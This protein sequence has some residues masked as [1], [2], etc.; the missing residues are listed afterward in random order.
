VEEEK[1]AECAATAQVVLKVLVCCMVL[2]NVL[3]KMKL[4]A[5][6][7]LYGAQLLDCFLHPDRCVWRLLLYIPDV[8]CTPYIRVV[9]PGM[10]RR[11]HACWRGPRSCGCTLPFP[12]RRTRERSQQPPKP[13]QAKIG[14][15]Q[16]NQFCLGKP[17]C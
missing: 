10:G 17:R 1:V 2:K 11:P 13:R 3:R 5:T 12:P 7:R 16:P 9:P 4:V 15:G 6:I 14:G 8:L